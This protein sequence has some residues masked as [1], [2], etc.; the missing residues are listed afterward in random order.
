MSHGSQLHKREIHGDQ[1]VTG[2]PA[3][4]RFTNNNLIPTENGQVAV[5][6][7]TDFSTFFGSPIGA[8]GVFSVV[9][10]L[11]TPLA[12]GAA[13]GILAGTPDGGQDGTYPITIRLTNDTGQIDSN[14]F[15]L[16]IAA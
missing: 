10:T 13:T 11:P 6:Y 5:A 4:P 16:V 12:I 9:G 3:F 1:G 14:Q 2:L 8:S 7:S 15:D